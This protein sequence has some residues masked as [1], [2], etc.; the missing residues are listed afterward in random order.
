MKSSAYANCLAAIKEVEDQLLEINQ[1]QIRAFTVKQECIQ[2]ED[3]QSRIKLKEVRGLIRK[4]RL[5]EIKALQGI[6][7]LKKVAKTCSDKR[8][9][10]KSIRTPWRSSFDIFVEAEAKHLCKLRS[11]LTGF[12]WDV[13]HMVPLKGKLASGLNVAHNLQV[14]PASINR[15]KCNKMIYTEPFE[16]M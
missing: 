6:N 3:Y 13:D 14:I 15:S 16:W 2:C 5:V 4:L 9:D 11:N 12:E 1:I 7:E 8:E 10:Y